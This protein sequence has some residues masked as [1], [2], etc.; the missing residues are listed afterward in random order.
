MT[1][2]NETNTGYILNINT[3]SWNKAF[4]R[5]IPMSECVNVIQYCPIYKSFHIFLYKFGEFTER[6]HHK[7]M[8]QNCDVFVCRR[9]NLHVHMMV[10][11]LIRQPD[12][13]KNAVMHHNK[14]L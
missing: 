5:L 7:E 12:S 6:L 9:V 2:F 10:N 11:D 8:F 14:V 3:S 1:A 4:E 13:T